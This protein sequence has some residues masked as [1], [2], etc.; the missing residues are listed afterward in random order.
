MHPL[1][2]K[3][4]IALRILYQIFFSIEYNVLFICLR[5]NRI[6]PFLEQGCVFQKRMKS[7]IAPLIL[8]RQVSYCT[9]F[10]TYKALSQLYITS[11][12]D[13]GTCRSYLRSQKSSVKLAK[14][15]ESKD[16]YS[17]TTCCF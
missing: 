14:T 9:N 11:F 8:I 3:C 16:L 5:V 7:F 6:A 4:F 15:V 2:H 10:S 17:N 13:R 12:L 1:H